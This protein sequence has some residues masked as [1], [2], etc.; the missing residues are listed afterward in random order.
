MLVVAELVVAELGLVVA[1]LVLVVAEQFLLRV[2]LPAVVVEVGPVEVSVACRNVLQVVSA[3]WV[4]GLEQVVVVVF[5]LHVPRYIIIM[6]CQTVHTS[7]S[8]LTFKS[9]LVPFAILSNSEP[10][11]NI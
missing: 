1:L 5:L 11:V 4:E 8:I 2:H 6:C 9:L 3:T 10:G 7:L